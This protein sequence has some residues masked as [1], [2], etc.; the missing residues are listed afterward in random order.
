MFQ[1]NAVHRK[2]E[3]S[4]LMGQ[5]QYHQ[6]W[7]NAGPIENFNCKYSYKCKKTKKEPSQILITIFA[8]L[9]TAACMKVR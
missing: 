1:A 7:N 9:E 2:F 4:K 6:L 8:V 3:S 5:N